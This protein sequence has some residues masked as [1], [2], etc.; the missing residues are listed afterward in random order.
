MALTPLTGQCSH[1]T[2]IHICH[3]G[4]PHITDAEVSLS[5]SSRIPPCPSLGESLLQEA[6]RTAIT[7]ACIIRTASTDASVSPSPLVQS[8]VYQIQS[9]IIHGMR[10]FGIAHLRD[11][12]LRFCLCNHRLTGYGHLHRLC[13]HWFSGYSYNHLWD[14][15]LKFHLYSHRPM[16]YGLLSSKGCVSSILTVQLSVFWGCVYWWNIGIYT[17]LLV[18]IYNYLRDVYFCTAG[19]TIDLS[20][21][22]YNYPGDA[23]ITAFSMHATGL[24]V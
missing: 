12:F 24:L 5:L 20:V 23:S 15:F 6:I 1:W 17:G 2:H 19:A 9:I 21:L 14:V 4:S 10:F 16:G 18:S 8:S 3:P 11:C 22:V 7:D 13:R